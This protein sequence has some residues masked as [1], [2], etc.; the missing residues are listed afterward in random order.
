MSLVAKIK[1]ENENSSPLVKPGGGG[2]KLS[3]KDTDFLLKVLMKSTFLGSEI[4]QAYSVIS[5][6][7]EIHRRKIEG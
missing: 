2:K 7:A 5:K 3:I 1:T 4:E 6:L